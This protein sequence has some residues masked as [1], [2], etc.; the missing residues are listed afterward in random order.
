MADYIPSSD[1]ELAAWAG[2]FTSKLTDHAGELEIPP[3]EVTAQQQL[4]SAFMG[5][6]TQASGPDRTTVITAAKNALVANIRG[7]ANFR[8]KNPK[9][10]VALLRDMGFPEK[11]NSRT[12]KPTP[13]TY[14]RYWIEQVGARTLKV[15]YS[16]ENGG[17]GSKPP[18]SAGTR[19]F[20]GV[21]AKPEDL[22][23]SKW[24]TRCPHTFHFR[25]EDRSK[26]AYFAARWENSKG[27][28]GPWGEIISEIIP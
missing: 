15:S 1:A 21:P 6:Y 8:L 26:C 24:V 19:V 7:L 3:A 28:E 5:L 11:D 14:P 17:R 9:I 23:A 10:P 2:N 12:P 20:Y 18:E 4:Y 25:E 27:D 22:P 13:R 16:V